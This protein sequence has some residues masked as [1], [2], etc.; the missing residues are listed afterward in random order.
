MT[1]ATKFSQG[2][3]NSCMDVR[4][5]MDP[6][7]GSMKHMKQASQCTRRYFKENMQKASILELSIQMGSFDRIVGYPYG[8]EVTA[9]TLMTLTY[10]LP[11]LPSTWY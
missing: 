11:L 8:R 2:N 4:V 7:L 9:K 3:S 6:L 1:L 5:S 10:F